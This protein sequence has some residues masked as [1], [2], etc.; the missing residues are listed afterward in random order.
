MLVYE[1]KPF[2][3]HHY[4]TLRDREN[5][6]VAGSSLGGL[7][8]L[9]LALTHAAVFSRIGLLSPSVWWDDRWIVRQLSATESAARPPLRI[10][11]DV[12]TGE[13]RMMKGAQL[14]ARM[15]E[16]RGWTRG[17]DFE[18]LEAE[19]AYHDERAWGQRTGL[20]LR[21]LFPAQRA[22]QWRPG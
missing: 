14:L 19:G 6:G 2:I 20:F 13:T 16:R 4:R 1:I 21:F 18:Y 12:G 7:L 8:S 9:H 11:L 3:D 15:L 10:W 5:T 22:D 17:V